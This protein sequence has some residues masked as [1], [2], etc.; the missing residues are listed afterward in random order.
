MYL[1]K[2]PVQT[3]KLMLFL[4]LKCL[5]NRLL[6]KD[7]MQTLYMLLVMNIVS[8]EGSNASIFQDPI[9]GFSV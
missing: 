3:Y 5:M 4:S 9:E 7:L 1:I 8:N 2:F 6:M